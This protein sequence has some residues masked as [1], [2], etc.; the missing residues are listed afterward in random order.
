M[1]AVNIDWDTDEQ[2]AMDDYVG[3]PSSVDIPSNVDEDDIAD[4][5]SNIYGFCVRGFNLIK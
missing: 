4:W 3:L 1:K 2:E 5:L